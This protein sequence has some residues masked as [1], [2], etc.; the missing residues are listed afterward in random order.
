MLFERIRGV[1]KTGTPVIYITHRLAEVRDVRTVIVY[2]QR[3][4]VAHASNGMTREV[5]FLDC[6]RWRRRQINVRIPP[7]I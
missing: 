1:V 7:V 4:A 6:L 5:D 2:T 3:N